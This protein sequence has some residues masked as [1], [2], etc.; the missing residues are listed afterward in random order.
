[1]SILLRP[2][3][4]AYGAGAAARRAM[5]ESGV[6]PRTHLDAPVISV[7]NLS[8]GGT[9]KT[10]VVAAIARMLQRASLEVAILSRG[11]RGS[12]EGD[13]LV[14]SDG[15][16]VVASPA[17]AGDEP[18]MLAHA[19]PGAVVAVGRRRGH[20]GAAVTRRF[21]RRVVLLDDGFQHLALERDLDV[22]CVD[23]ETFEDHPLPEGRLREFPS[24]ASRA[25]VLV[26]FDSRIGG[27]DRGALRIAARRVVEGFVDLRGVAAA[28]PQR[29][30]LVSAI[31]RPQRFESDIAAH[32]ID[33]AGHDRHRDHHAFTAAELM[34]ASERAA[35]QGA[36]AVVTTEKNAV[37]LERPVRGAVPVLVM[38]IGIAFDPEPALRDKL[39]A[40]ARAAAWQ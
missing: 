29:A 7:G 37:W 40:V 32:G 18:V 26:D 6:L 12:F 25:D 20:L 3:S 1:M 30:H 35:A 5:Y 33:I 4:L 17:E 24:T 31:A 14:V 19:L 11:Y 15:T 21:P 13:C 38:R 22:L 10:P 39:L 9:G 34:A 8:V 23:G 2:L 36:G 28:P 16:R 27:P